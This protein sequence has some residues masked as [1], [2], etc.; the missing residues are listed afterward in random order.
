MRRKYKLGDMW[1]DDFDYD[2]MI[3]MG[4]KTNSSWSISDL[5]KLYDSM[6]DVNYHTPNKYLG[7]AI[8]ALENDMPEVADI[9]FEK[10]HKELNEIGN[11]E[12]EIA[13]FT[14]DFIKKSLS[15]YYESY[16]KG[17][18]AGRNDLLNIKDESDVADYID[19]KLGD[20]AVA[21]VTEVYQGKMYPYN[22]S[23]P[24]LHDLYRVVLKDGTKL[25]FLRQHGRPKWSGNVNY[26]EDIEVEI[27]DSFAF[28]GIFKSSRYNYG[29]SWKLDHNRHNKSQDYE[30]PMK[31]RKRRKYD[32]GGMMSKESHSDQMIDIMNRDRES[33]MLKNYQVSG[34]IIIDYP[35]LDSDTQEFSISVM[36]SSKEEAKR[37]AEEEMITKHLVNEY[38]TAVTGKNQYYSGDVKIEDVVE[39]GRYA[40]GGKMDDGKLVITSSYYDEHNEEL[41]LYVDDAIYCTIIFDHNP[42][43]DEV[44]EIISDIEYEHNHKMAKGGG[45]E[46]TGRHHKH[47]KVIIQVEDYYGNDI[48]SFESRGKTISFVQKNLPSNWGI[49]DIDDIEDE[50][51]IVVRVEI[52]GNFTNNGKVTQSEINNLK[53]HLQ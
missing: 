30:I 45:V 13:E 52:E 11:E 48:T 25:T 4:L 21:S 34:I 24:Y 33:E 42:S 43:D 40:D 37:I 1:R 10:F 50:D 28:G 6:E 15:G 7:Q 9:K 2:G 29:R 26:V 38:G 49:A 5:Q 31:K 23:N 27:V 51:G 22:M 46:N 19:G 14:P 12:E 36:A 39:I 18:A 41:Q 20:G 3:E 47:P 32:D 44:D 17:I 8:F 35:H 53:H 16:D